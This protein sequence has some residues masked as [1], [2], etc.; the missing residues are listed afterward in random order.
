M[1]DL[2][3]RAA[4]VVLP[5]GEASADIGVTGERIS[6]VA[7]HGALTGGAVIEYGDDVVLLPGLVDTHVHVNEPGRTAWEGF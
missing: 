3:W 7:A 6:A 5:E 2:I 1:T 4:R